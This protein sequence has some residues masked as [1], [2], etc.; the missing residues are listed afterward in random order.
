MNWPVKASSYLSYEINE[1]VQYTKSTFV[2][3]GEPF[4]EGCIT[5]WLIVSEVSNVTDTCQSVEMLQT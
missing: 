2:I 3:V 5:R 4:L 1:L